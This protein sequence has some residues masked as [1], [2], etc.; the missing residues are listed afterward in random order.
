MQ[1]YFRI[2]NMLT[3]FLAQFSGTEYNNATCVT[4]YSYQDFAS[5][6]VYKN[7]GNYT[8]LV[9]TKININSQLCRLALFI[10]VILGI[11]NLCCSDTVTQ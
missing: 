11:C 7:Y 4:N 9:S 2:S 1:C 5:V 8:V 10:I 6:S 3:V